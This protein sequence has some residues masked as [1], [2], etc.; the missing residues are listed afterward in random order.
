M[1]FSIAPRLVLALKRIWR[2]AAYFP[3]FHIFFVFPEIM[4]PF[5]KI[6]Y[7]DLLLTPTPI[8]YQIVNSLLFLQYRGL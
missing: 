2:F 7:T 1:N 6:L 5:E 8:Y 4:S 3:L